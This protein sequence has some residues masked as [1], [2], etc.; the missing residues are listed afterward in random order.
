MFDEILSEIRDP[1]VPSTQELE[2]RHLSEEFI[3]VLGIIEVYDEPEY[4]HICVVSLDD[5]RADG[6]DYDG[7]ALAL[8]WHGF[9]VRS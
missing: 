8:R 2:L 6:L 1:E 4:I 3:Q 7:F 9:S 5:L